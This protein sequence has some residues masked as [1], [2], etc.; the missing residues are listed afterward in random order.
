MPVGLRCLLKRP[1]PPSFSLSLQEAIPVGALAAPHHRFIHKKFNKLLVLSQF[2]GA[3]YWELPAAPGRLLLPACGSHPAV[4]AGTTWEHCWVP[5]L[6]ESGVLCPHPGRSRVCPCL[7]RVPHSSGWVLPWVSPLQLWLLGAAP[8]LTLG[9]AAL[10]ASP[11]AWGAFQHA[12][13]PPRAG[14]REAQGTQRTEFSAWVLAF[15][16]AGPFVPVWGLCYLPAMLGCSGEGDGGELGE[17]QCW[18]HGGGG[19]AS[20]ACQ[21][22]GCRGDHTG[23]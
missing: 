7:G 10:S 15:V 2:L 21:A 9:C 22:G 14:L 12:A 1:Q 8:T 20:A 4:G 19:M 16:S 17:L 5:L 13:P 6:S 23:T 3:A 11:A 18:L